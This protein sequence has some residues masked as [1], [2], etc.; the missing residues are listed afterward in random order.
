MGTS[1]RKF[2]LC[3]VFMGYQ[4]IAYQQRKNFNLKLTGSSLVWIFICFL[5]DFGVLS[6]VLHGVNLH[7]LD[8][9]QCHFA[10]Q[11]M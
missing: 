10:H 11:K 2:L 5:F 1:G 3:Q 6:N 9:F 4:V 7:Y 8:L